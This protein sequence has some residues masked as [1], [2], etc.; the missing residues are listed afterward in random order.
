MFI[1]S[2]VQLIIIKY[3]LGAKYCSRSLW[4][5]YKYDIV[6]AFTEATIYE[7]QV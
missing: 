1:Y 4:Y 2:F 7:E 5:K 3:L 6:P